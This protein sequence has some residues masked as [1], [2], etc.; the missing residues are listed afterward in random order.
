MKTGR[1]SNG[2]ISHPLHTHSF[3]TLSCQDTQCQSLFLYRKESWELLKL[4]VKWKLNSTKNLKIVV[5][6][7]ILNYRKTYKVETGTAE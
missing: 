7:F 1:D 2:F 3:H 4:N 5:S 6:A